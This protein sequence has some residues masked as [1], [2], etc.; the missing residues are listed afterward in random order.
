[1]PCLRFCCLPGGLRRP[2]SAGRRGRQLGGGPGQARR[3]GGLGREGGRA[4][5]PADSS[6]FPVPGKQRPGLPALVSDG[7]AELGAREWGLTWKGGEE[8]SG[9]FCQLRGAQGGRVGWPSVGWGFRAQ[10][11]PGGPESPGG[12]CSLRVRG[13]LEVRPRPP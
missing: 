12:D 11:S 4:A 7:A 13:L 3:R 10:G 6:S 5:G 8:T 1:M 9:P 2:V